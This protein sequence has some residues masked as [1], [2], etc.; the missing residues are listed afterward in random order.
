M[1]CNTLAKPLDNTTKHIKRIY[2]AFGLTSLIKEPTR[3][4][5]DTQTLID[6]AITNRPDLVAGSGV[7]PCGVSDHD[8]IYIIR[9]ARLPKLKSDSQILNVRNFKRFDTSNFTEDLV[10]YHWI[11]SARLMKI[12]TQF[13]CS[14]KLYLLTYSTRMLLLAL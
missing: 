1:N 2:D 5:S 13:G 14:G 10:I 4:T 6:H 11:L 12:Q 9:T 8:V 7:I 3:T